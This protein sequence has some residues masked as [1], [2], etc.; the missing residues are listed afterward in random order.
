LTAPLAGSPRDREL[1]PTMEVPVFRVLQQINERPAIFSQTTV[2]A[3]WTDPHISEQML[4]FHLDGSV[5]LSSGTTEFIEAAVAWIRDTFHLTDHTRVLDLGCG[6]GLYANRLARA[7]ADVT[8]VDFSSRSIAYARDI[9]ARDGPTVTYINDDYLTWDS[10]RRFDLVM[11]IMRDYCALAPE[12]RRV[13]LRKVESLLEPGGAFL[14]DVESMAALESRG[15]S[16]GYEA[17]LEGGFWSASSYFAFVNT[18]L[19]P[20]DGV[21]LDKYV[22]VEPDRTRTIYNWLQHFDP[23][24]LGRELAEAGLEIAS[25]LGDVTGRPFDPRATEFAV[26]ARRRSS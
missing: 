17:S 12:Q 24:R 25:I 14:F 4:R 21:T 2:A 15:E 11:M 16:S 19:Y 7:G 13:L 3:L 23:D 20:E 5:A 10:I 9:A 22:I 1:T 26:V 18:F 8:G 6:P